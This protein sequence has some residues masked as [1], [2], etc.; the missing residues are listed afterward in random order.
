MH[1]ME[2]FQ[3]QYPTQKPCH[4]ICPEGRLFSSELDSLCGVGRRKPIK[5]PR[6]QV[7]VI[8]RIHKTCG[9][10]VCFYQAE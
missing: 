4:K 1:K 10:F 9:G 6:P 2:M 8:E 5:H 3:K 7:L